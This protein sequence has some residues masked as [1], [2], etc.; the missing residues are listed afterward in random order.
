MVSFLFF[1]ALYSVVGAP[2]FIHNCVFLLFVT[3]I[4]N[5]QNGLYG[6]LFASVL[7]FL[8]IYIILKHDSSVTAIQVYEHILLK[9]VKINIS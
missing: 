1:I 9:Y 3:P 2:K 7:F 6:G 8:F 5:I 4:K